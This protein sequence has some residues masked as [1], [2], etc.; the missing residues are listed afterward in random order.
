MS[1][2]GTGGAGPIFLAGVDRSGI[3]LLGEVLE[4][5]PAVSMTRRTNF[6]AHYA[7]R[8]GSLTSA[9]AVDRCLDEMMRNTR[10]RVLRPDR[11]RLRAAFL[12]GPPTY[13]RLF[14]Q[15]QLQLMELRGCTRWGDKSLGAEEFA[16]RI[17]SAYP[18]AMMIHVLRD[19]RDRYASQCHHRPRRPGGPGHGAALWHWSERLA[20]RHSRIYTG[21]YLVVRYEDLV[22]DPG[23]W[24]DTVRSFLDLEVPPTTGGAGAR[25][26]TTAS[27][28][29]HRR[30]LTPGQRRFLQLA[31]ARGMRRW[32]YPSEQVDLTLAPTL[33]FWTRTVPVESVRAAA[34]R[35][36]RALRHQ[37]GR[38]PSARRVQAIEQGDG[39]D[40]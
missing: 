38:V 27:V 2:E 16:G 23:H 22:S 17:L 29:R 19:P 12:D 32:R 9:A 37:I 30:D 20:R 3:G 13:E 34:W 1:W 4:C 11:A 24:L 10:V 28:G 40:R 39:G 26:L 18:T 15:L 14:E 21:R 6:W 7:G 36:G 33:A 31:L 35:V 25:E 8:F 5:H